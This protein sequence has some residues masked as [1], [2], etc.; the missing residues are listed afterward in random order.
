M[1]NLVNECVW[2]SITGGRSIKEKN[3]DVVVLRPLQSL[4][5]THTVW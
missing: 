5:E 3:L 2:I 1:Y 4:K